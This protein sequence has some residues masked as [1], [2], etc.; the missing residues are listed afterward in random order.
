MQQVSQS[1]L[2]EAVDPFIGLPVSVDRAEV[3]EVCEDVNGDGVHAK[4][5][6]GEGEPT[7]LPN[8]LRS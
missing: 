3:D 6:P 2:S 8:I 4:R 5:D 1:D 7:L